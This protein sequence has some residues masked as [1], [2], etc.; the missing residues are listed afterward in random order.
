M[1]PKQNENRLYD[2]R[3]LEQYLARGVIKQ[4]DYEKFL[5]TVPDDEGNLE[6]IKIDEEE[7]EA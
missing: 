4:N 6:L 2:V 7:N 3:T 5:K 1:N